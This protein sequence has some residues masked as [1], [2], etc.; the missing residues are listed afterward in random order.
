MEIFRSFSK[1]IFSKFDLC[2]AQNDET[3]FYLK[4]LG[5]QKIKKAGN[6]KFCEPKLTLNNDK[7]INFN[8]FLN[9][10]KK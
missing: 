2:L 8:N 1:F 4:K 9:K 3:E 6:L 5:S 7:K 10:K